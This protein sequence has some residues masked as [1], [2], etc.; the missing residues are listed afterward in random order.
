[1][2][3]RR[4]RS[5]LVLMHTIAYDIS[6]D[7]LSVLSD[8]LMTFLV[9]QSSCKGGN[10]TNGPA[11]DSALDVEMQGFYHASKTPGL[12]SFSNCAEWHCALQLKS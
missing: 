2:S 11:D 5:E 4:R 9:A 10:G 12:V 3:H 8:R 1:V 7:L 6:I